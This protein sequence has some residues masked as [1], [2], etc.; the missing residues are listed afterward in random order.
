VYLGHA[1]IE[2]FRGGTRGLAPGGLTVRAVRDLGKDG[3]GD[4]DLDY[5]V[6]VV[7]TPGAVSAVAPRGGG[8]RFPMLG[9]TGAPEAE[10]AGFLASSGTKHERLKFGEQRSTD[11]ICTHNFRDLSQSLV[12][13]HMQDP[14]LKRSVAPPRFHC[15]SR[16]ST[17]TDS[18]AL[19]SPRPMP[20][21]GR[22]RGKST[23]S[24]SAFSTH[25]PRV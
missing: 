10:K 4:W 16:R 22:R 20:M 12:S 6:C 14:F 8:R 18:T 13:L 2:D 19:V 7:R 5:G 3:I 25:F 1:S 21:R 15:S 23:S 24:K 9:N 17:S 11:L